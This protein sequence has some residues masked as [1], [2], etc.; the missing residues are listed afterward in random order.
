MK[1]EF[2]WYEVKTKVVLT[3][4]VKAKSEDEAMGAVYDELSSET[5]KDV[6]AEEV[7]DELSV[8]IKCFQADYE[9]DLENQ[10]QSQDD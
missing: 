3:F 7:Q 9:I 4:M 8:A 1:D 10:W 6:E 2:K 5:I